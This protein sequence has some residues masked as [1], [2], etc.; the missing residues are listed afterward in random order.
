MAA[1]RV[2]WWLVGTIWRHSAQPPGVPSSQRKI[3]RTHGRVVL[4]FASPNVCC[5]IENG[6]KWTPSYASSRCVRGRPH[7]VDEEEQRLGESTVLLCQEAVPP[8][9]L[10]Q[11]PLL[12][13][14]QVQKVVTVLLKTS[15]PH[16]HTCTLSEYW[17]NAIIDLKKK[18]KKGYIISWLYFMM[19]LPASLWRLL[20]SAASQ[21]LQL[22]SSPPVH[23][24]SD[25]PDNDGNI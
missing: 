18:K 12:A 13:L 20:V 5:N 22:D 19:K 6:N 4:M 17:R 21:E 2:W 15:F 10:L 7:L 1:G 23:T 9:L 14:P 24:P 25:F 11:D 3:I 16:R 8:L